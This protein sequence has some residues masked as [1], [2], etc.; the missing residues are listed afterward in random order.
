MANLLSNQ[1]QHVGYRCGVTLEVDVALHGIGRGGPCRRGLVY[2][3]R[4][5][6]RCNQEAHRDVWQ[7][8]R[9]RELGVGHA[10][11]RARRLPALDVAIRLGIAYRHTGANGC[12]K[13]DARQGLRYQLQM[14]LDRL[15]RLHQA[16]TAWGFRGRLL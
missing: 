9:H 4:R 2:V 10:R 7:V 5:C 3:P 14:A 1:N 11:R 8:V 6:G 13:A 12:T 15:E 16:Q